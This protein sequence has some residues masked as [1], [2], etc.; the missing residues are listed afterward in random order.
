MDTR[1]SEE[2]GYTLIELLVTVTLM[3][4]AFG[5]V[6]GGLGLFFKIQST[7]RANAAIDTEIRNYA[8]RLLDQPYVDCA[9]TASY[10]A[11]TQPTGYTT[12]VTLTYWDGK[13]PAGYGSTCTTDLGLQQITIKLSNSRGDFGTLTLGKSR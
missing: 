8:E 2:R 3:A 10:T 5:A 4:I 9:T 7:Q 12:T 11:A 13:L 1:R 6:F